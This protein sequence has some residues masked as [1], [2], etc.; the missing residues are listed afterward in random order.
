M[1]TDMAMS[2]ES[3]QLVNSID[4]GDIVFAKSKDDN[5]WYRTIVESVGVEDCTVY[6][7]D[8]GFIET[9]DLTR[10]GRLGVLEL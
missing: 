8:W 1:I 7:F 2:I 3:Q 6:L 10:I 4:V 5:A 9:L